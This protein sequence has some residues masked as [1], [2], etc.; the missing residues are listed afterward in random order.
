M[1]MQTTLRVIS[2]VIFMPQS[3][4]LTLLPKRQYPPSKT[5]WPHIKC[6]P[7]FFTLDEH[8]MIKQVTYKPSSRRLS[9]EVISSGFVAPKYP[10]IE[11]AILI[12]SKVGEP[13]AGTVY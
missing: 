5:T 2:L 10:Y 4:K 9:L 3:L 1:L 12:G 13:V 8:C 7:T 6:S 11:A